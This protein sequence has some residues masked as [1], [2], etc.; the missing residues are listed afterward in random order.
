MDGMP[1]IAMVPPIEDDDEPALIS[2]K[3]THDD[4]EMRRFL[5]KIAPPLNSKRYKGQ[6]GRIGVLGNFLISNAT[7]V[8]QCC[9]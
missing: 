1:P 8:C 9:G 6:G 4:R 5:N 3:T 7:S 2:L